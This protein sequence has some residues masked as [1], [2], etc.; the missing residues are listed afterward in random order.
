MKSHEI[1]INGLV[2]VVTSQVSRSNL[3]TNKPLWKKLPHS[4][5]WSII[6]FQHQM[7]IW[8]VCHICRHA[9]RPP[10]HTSSSWSRSS[11]TISSNP[12]G[13]SAVEQQRPVAKTLRSN[14]QKWPSNSGDWTYLTI[15]TQ[16]LTIIGDLTSWSWKLEWF[17]IYSIYPNKLLY[18]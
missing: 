14:S 12:R 2:M 13:I 16:S 1:P 18:M 10:L 15:R 7:V 8:E 4:I 11:S 6:M 3:T 9:H 17:E 5:H